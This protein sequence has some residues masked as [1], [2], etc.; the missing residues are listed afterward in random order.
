MV[1]RSRSNQTAVSEIVSARCCSTLRATAAGSGPDRRSGASAVSEAEALAVGASPHAPASCIASTSTSSRARRVPGGFAAPRWLATYAAGRAA[2]GP[3]R[4]RAPWRQQA[5]AHAPEPRRLRPA[6]SR[7][8]GAGTS[9]VADPTASWPSP[10]AGGR[11]GRLRAKVDASMPGSPRVLLTAPS[12]ST[13]RV[14]SAASRR[15]LRSWNGSQAE[16]HVARR[17]AMQSASR[18]AAAT[19][20]P[21][22]ADAQRPPAPRGAD[23]L[24]QVK[25]RASALDRRE[26]AGGGASAEG[27]RSWPGDHP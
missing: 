21:G 18:A 6:E 13:M 4:G 8:A 5:Q 1:P 24:E 25:H 14:P 17:I 23:E 3:R 26:A 27:T 22:P 2:A 7:P 15:S 11:G 12:P 16:G 19:R 20:S 10:R 9:A